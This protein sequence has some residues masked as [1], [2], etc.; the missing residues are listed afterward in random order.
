MNQFMY[1]F[2]LIVWGLNFIAVKIQGDSISLE[3]SLFYRTIIALLL[4]GLLLLIKKR[5]MNTG[6]NFYAICGFGIFNFAISYL[7]LY[8]GTFYSS[9]A[10]VTLIFSMKSISTPI[11]ISIIHKKKVDSRVYI[12]GLLGILGVFIIL[13]PHF[14]EFK[15]VFILGILLSILGTLVTSLGDVLSS[16]NNSKGVDPVIANFLGMLSASIFMYCIILI[17]GETFTLTTDINYWFGLLYLSIFASFLAWLFYLILIKNIGAIKSSYMVV[18]FPAVGGI[19]S[20][21]MGESN[22]NLYLITGI[23]LSMYGAK[24]S[25]ENN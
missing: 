24:M 23:L 15:W 19:A 12:G 10:L 14:K 25:L 5:K 7:L 18:L 2:C 9:A 3:V 22:L 1:L 13:I 16:Y 20:I 17:K 8:Y 4:F 21:V 6:L 11:M